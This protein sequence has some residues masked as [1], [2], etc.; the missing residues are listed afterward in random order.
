[1]KSLTMEVE[2]G[3]RRARRPRT[4]IARFSENGFNCGKK[5]EHNAPPHKVVTA[6]TPSRRRMEKR[7]S[8]TFT[9]KPSLTRRARP[10]QQKPKGRQSSTTTTTGWSWS[11]SSRR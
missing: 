1:M 6:K 8:S 7:S 2:E 5:P 9:A 10:F 11:K 3:S 4:G